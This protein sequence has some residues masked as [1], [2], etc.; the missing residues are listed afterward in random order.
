[1]DLNLANYP[2]EVVAK[3][4]ESLYTGIYFGWAKVDNGEVHKMVMSVGWNPYY[5]NDKKSM[6][7]QYV[8]YLGIWSGEW[9]IVRGDAW[10]EAGCVYVIV[11]AWSSLKSRGVISLYQAKSYSLGKS[12]IT[13]CHFIVR[14]GSLS[15]VH[16]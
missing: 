4:S 2:E 5:N 1:M 15:S 11:Q 10:S 7:S 16:V 8:C 14:A 13:T 6:V 9:G 3:Y 12:K